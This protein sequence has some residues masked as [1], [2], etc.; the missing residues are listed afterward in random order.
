[1]A[2]NT[3]KV[4]K[5]SDNIEEL[6]ATAVAITPGMLVE[7]TSAGTVQAHSSP[8]QNAM[9][10][11]ALEDELQ[12]NGIDDA[13]AVSAR[14]QVWTPYRGDLVYAIVADGEN[15]AIGDELES[16]G[17]GT[18]RKHDADSAGAVEYPMAV[19][20]IARSA[21]DLSGGPLGYDKRVL[22]EIV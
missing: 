13:Y 20:G 16:N 17:D 22:V 1:M 2:Y 21:I 6:T 8:G 9:P 7:V 19:V 15:I 18:L 4:K 5:Y 14:I 12:G 11:F 3:I 10:K